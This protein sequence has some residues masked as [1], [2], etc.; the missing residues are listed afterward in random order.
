MVCCAIGIVYWQDRQQL[1]QRIEL[2]ERTL[3]PQAVNG[4]AWAPEQATGPPNTP[5]P[6][7]QSTAWASLK[8]ND[9]I[10]WLELNY[11]KRVKPSSISIHQ[12]Y[13]PGA[14]I[15]V[16]A[17]DRSGNEVTLW[18][19]TDPIAPG[20]ASGVSQIPL[21]TSLKSDR[22]RIYLDCTLVTGWNEV[23]AVAIHYGW[24]RTMWAESATASSSYGNAGNTQIMS[25]PL[26]LTR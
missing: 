14:L 21:N 8:P 23:D 18:T 10:E 19:G 16:S 12:N 22:Y 6:G 5:T 7:D 20:K 15:R 25:Y 3:R 17:F 13:N 2:L 1:L 26:R 11:G 4:I 9:Q 24:G